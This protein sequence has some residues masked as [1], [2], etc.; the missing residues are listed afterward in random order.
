[1]DRQCVKRT[2]IPAMIDGSLIGGSAQPVLPIIT[3]DQSAKSC[4]AQYRTGSRSP[5]LPL[6]NTMGVGCELQAAQPQ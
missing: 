3:T 4:T 5:R 2:G 6:A 1:M